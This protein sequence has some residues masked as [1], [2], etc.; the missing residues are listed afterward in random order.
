MIPLLGFSTYPKNYSYRELFYLDGNPFTSLLDAPD[1][2]KWWNIKALV[3]FKWNAY[4]RIYYFIIWA[5]FTTYMCCF[6]IV[7]T[8]PVDKISWNNQVILLTATICFGIIHF[9]FEVRQFLHSPI[10]YIASPCNWFDLTA[11]LFP[12]T[13]SFIWL[14]VK[15]PS[16]WI[17]T[18]AVFLLETRFLLF[19]RVLGYFGKYFAIM[20]G[21]AQKVFSFLIVLGIMVLIFAHSFASFIKAY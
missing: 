18:I 15:I 9:I 2:Y 8:I 7:S 3:N 13:I 11:I 21:V 10:T 14:Y 12:T 6:V 20:I 19:F 16:V 17:I 1:Y 4:G 5:L